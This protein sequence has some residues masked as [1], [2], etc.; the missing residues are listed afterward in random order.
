MRLLHVVAFS[1]KLRWLAQT[2]TITLKTQL[3]A[4]NAHWKR[5]SQL[6]FSFY[7]MSTEQIWCHNC[8]NAIL[9]W[10]ATVV[11]NVRLQHAVVFSKKWR[12]L[13]PTKLI[14][15]KTQTHTVNARWKRLSQLSLKLHC[16][17]CGIKFVLLSISSMFFARFFVR[18][19]FWQLFST[20]VRTYVH[21]KKLPKRHS[22]E[23]SA[24][25]TLMKINVAR[26]CHILETKLC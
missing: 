9:G 25:K 23:R 4:I 5:L 12:W 13:E 3:H 2:K 18:M 11:F 10:V 8:S 17:S 7:N 15:L 21:N 1:K 20:Y 26:C 6:S 22:Y 16:C 19:S 24:W 14:T